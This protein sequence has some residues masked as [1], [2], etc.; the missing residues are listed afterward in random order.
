MN[1][2]LVRLWNKVATVVFDGR[3]FDISYRACTVSSAS[4]PEMAH[5]EITIVKLIPSF[6]TSFKNTLVLV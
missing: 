2:A 6:M 5:S 4:P 3:V 1:I